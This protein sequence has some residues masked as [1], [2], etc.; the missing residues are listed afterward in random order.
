MKRFA[1]VALHA[2]CW[3][4]RQQCQLL[5]VSPSG[6]YAWRKRAPSP[7]AEPA[8]A[9]GQ[10]AAHRVFTIHASRYGQRRLRAQLRREG[11]AVCRQRLRGWLSASGLRALYTRAG[12]RP[13]RTTQADPQAIAAVTSSPPGP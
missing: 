6:Y 7:A 10:V 9:A 5:G 2:Q 4:V 3:P 8:P 11:H 12:T 1:F 13:L